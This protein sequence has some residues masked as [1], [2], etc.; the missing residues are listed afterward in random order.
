MSR[1]QDMT[2]IEDCNGKEKMP[3]LKLSC[4][5]FNWAYG[6]ELYDCHQL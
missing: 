2:D 3:K 5:N 6:E 1:L 4:S